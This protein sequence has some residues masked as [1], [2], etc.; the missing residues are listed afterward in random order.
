MG[1]WTVLFHWKSF[2]CRD[3]L[4]PVADKRRQYTWKHSHFWNSTPAW[5][6]LS[7][8]LSQT[9]NRTAEGG[10][11]T[12]WH[13]LWFL[14]NLL[15]YAMS[16]HSFHLP[17]CRFASSRFTSLRLD[18]TSMHV[19]SFLLL[20]LHLSVSS[21]QV[22]LLIIWYMQTSPAAQRI[23]LSLYKPELNE[24]KCCVHV[25][26]QKQV[27]VYVADTRWLTLANCRCCSFTH[28]KTAMLRKCMCTE[29]LPALARVQFIF[30]SVHIKAYK[31][32]KRDGSRRR[33]QL[34]KW[35]ASL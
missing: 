14:P 16:D 28:T 12:C 7:C 8:Y 24:G 18:F 19:R 13:C 34:Y 29:R 21:R 6:H 22:K 35:P 9:R 32:K 2:E 31:Q 25:R 20:Y 10:A 4:P 3:R 27:T 17:T 1:F 33:K 15:F 23:A 30:G 11:G 26:Y 5:G